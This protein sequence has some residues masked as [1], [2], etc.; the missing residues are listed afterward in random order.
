MKPFNALFMWRGALHPRRGLSGSVILARG[1][2]G[3]KPVTFAYGCGA[4]SR[5]HQTGLQPRA[6]ASR[7]AGINPVLA[8][9]M[10][11]IIEARALAR[12]QGGQGGVLLSEKSHKATPDI[13]TGDIQPIAPTEAPKPDIRTDETA[14]DFGLSYPR[15]FHQRNRAAS[16]GR[17]RNASHPHRYSCCFACQPGQGR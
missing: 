14:S 15:Y 3:E 8:L 2:E 10:K 7:Y 17:T 12:Q 6:R 16:T 1:T 13:F 9:R 4:P 11:P 5:T